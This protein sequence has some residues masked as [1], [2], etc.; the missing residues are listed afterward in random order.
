MRGF[1]HSNISE[2]RQQIC[3]RRN[4]H[5]VY[6]VAKRKL[7]PLYILPMGLG[8]RSTE[9]EFE[10]RHDAYDRHNGAFAQSGY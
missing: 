6:L 5:K 9:P 3:R 4:Q 7:P 2:P 8:E 10:I 1:K